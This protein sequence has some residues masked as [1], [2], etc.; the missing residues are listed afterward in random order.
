[1]ALAKSLSAVDWDAPILRVMLWV[2]AE[3]IDQGFRSA[4]RVQFQRATIDQTPSVLNTEIP[5]ER[6]TLPRHL[7]DFPT[8]TRQTHSGVVLASNQVLATEAASAH[9]PGLLFRELQPAI[10]GK[11][12]GLLFRELQPAIPG[13]PRNPKPEPQ[14]P[15]SNTHQT[16][17][18]EHLT[19]PT[20]PQP[21]AELAPSNHRPTPKEPQHPIISQFSRQVQ[22]TRLRLPM[23]PTAT[24]EGLTRIHKTGS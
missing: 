19:Q 22:Q 13:K 2:R 14:T 3:V 6:L 4:A 15:T 9:P 5:I 1:V 21:S 20:N 24:E 17:S 16:P 11:P 8:G 23:G 12:P 10:P 18:P 7:L